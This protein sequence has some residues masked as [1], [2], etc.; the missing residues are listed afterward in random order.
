MGAGNYVESWNR[1]TSR[2]PREHSYT[3]HNMWMEVLVEL[4][5]FGMAAY[6]AMLGRAGA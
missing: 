5:L 6:L 4:G 1:Y 3:A 2:N